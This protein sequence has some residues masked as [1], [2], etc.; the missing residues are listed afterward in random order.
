MKKNPKVKK[1]LKIIDKIEKVRSKNNVNWMDVL[2]LALNYFPHLVDVQCGNSKMPPIGYFNDDD[3]LKIIIKKTW[4][5]EEKHGNNK[6]TENRFRQS[7]KLYQES[8]MFS[9]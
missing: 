4:K 5:Y 7:L 3:L 6:F 9:R 8:K 2:R 1:Y